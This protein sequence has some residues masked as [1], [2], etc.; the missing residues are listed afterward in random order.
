MLNIIT[1]YIQK[2]YQSVEKPQTY[3]SALEAYI[4]SKNPQNTHDVEYWTQEF[5]RNRN[6]SIKEWAL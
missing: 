6:R 5:D 4:V 1:G 3:S 2:M